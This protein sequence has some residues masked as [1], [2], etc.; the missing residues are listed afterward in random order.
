MKLFSSFRKVLLAAALLAVPAMAHA[1]AFVSVAVAPPA[2]PIYTQPLC[3]GD[4][5]IWTP[6][7]WAYGDDGYFWV[8]GAWVL[9]PYEGALWTPG[10]W[11]WGVGFC[12][13]HPGYW[14]RSIGY[15]GGINYGFGYFGSGFYGGY[16]NG[17][18]YFNNGSIN[19]INVANMHNVYSQHVNSAGFGGSR[20]SVE[21][22]SAAMQHSNAI[23]SNAYNHGG[24][25][26]SH[27]FAE[28][29][30]GYSHSYV[31]N[32]G[33]SHAAPSYSSHSYS[34]PSG[35]SHF[36]GGGFSGGSS[37]FSGGGGSF[38]HRR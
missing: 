21:N 4:G 6:G 13:W 11:G 2:I 34:A 22:R 31:G 19:R 23:A 27:S 33:Y 37:H 35:G 18:R 12:A 25:T 17:G 15:Y 5:Y 9:A 29:N 36:S 38:T 20:E 7:Y 8:D 30:S 3:P 1:G 16:W 10:Y 26:A 24:G 14:G 28:G 32:S